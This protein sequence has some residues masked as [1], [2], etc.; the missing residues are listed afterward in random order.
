M[1][2]TRRGF[3]S[4]LAALSGGAA[5]PRHVTA[6]SKVFAEADTLGSPT[7]E[8]VRAMFDLRPDRILR[9]I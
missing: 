8:E 5:L 4:A 1:I 2:I 7:W 9:A 3:V 6:T